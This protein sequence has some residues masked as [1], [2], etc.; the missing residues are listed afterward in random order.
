M[1]SVIFRSCLSRWATHTAQKKTL[2][3]LDA[4]QAGL[5]SS[6]ASIQRGESRLQPSPRG[7]PRHQATLEQDQSQVRP[8]ARLGLAAVGSP[9]WDREMTERRQEVGRWGS[10]AQADKETDL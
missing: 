7:Y 9:T 8:R 5:L 3:S 10:A 4:V 1:P 2:L 6:R